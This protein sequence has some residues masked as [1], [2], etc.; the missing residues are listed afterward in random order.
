MSGSEETDP[1]Q[2]LLV[3][4]VLGLVLGLGLVS[5]SEETYPQQSLLVLA[6]FHL[7]RGQVDDGAL[8]AVPLA[9]V[10]VD[11]GAPHHHVALH[12]AVGVGLQEVEV[13]L[14]GHDGAK[15]GGRGGGR[16]C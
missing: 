8:H 4:L 1:Q 10:Q 12:P 7:G 13:A 9:A 3:E 11:V 15:V 6:V 5:G 2:S 16:L 14:L